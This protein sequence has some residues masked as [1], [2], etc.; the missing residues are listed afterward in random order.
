MIST[1]DIK[2]NVKL[3]SDHV[4]AKV[5]LNLSTGQKAVVAAVPYAAGDVICPFSAGIT[6]SHPSALTLQIADDKHITLLPD[7][8]QYTNH[9]CAP[10][11]FFDTTAMELVCLKAMQPGDEFTFF[12]PGTEWEM[13][14]PFDC[15]CGSSVCLKKID[16]AANLSWDILNRY[17]LTDFIR[18][19]KLKSISPIHKDK[20]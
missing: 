19:K 10:T 9:S 3:I 15:Y 13:A 14:Q 7:C 6:L 4:F 17:R 11:V 12:Y 16:G 18:Q 8:L 5:V 1:P 2:V 20:S